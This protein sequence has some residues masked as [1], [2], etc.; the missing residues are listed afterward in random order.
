MSR[1]RSEGGATVVRLDAIAMV[2]TR[3]PAI[4][5]YGSEI[6]VRPA[7]SIFLNRTRVNENNKTLADRAVKRVA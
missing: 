3:W 5:S 7:L 1:T 6:T 4:S 2:P